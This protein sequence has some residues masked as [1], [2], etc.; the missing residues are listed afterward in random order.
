MVAGALK[1]YPFDYTQTLWVCELYRPEAT[2][3]WTAMTRPPRDLGAFPIDTRR[4]A[5]ALKWETAGEA[6][7]NDVGMVPIIPFENRVNVL[8]GGA[9]E[10]EDCVPILQRIDRLTLDQMLTSHYS[11]FRQK[12][13]TGLQVPT[14]PETGQ[15]VEPY[16]A[17]VNRLWVNENP[18]GSF[19]TFDASDL[20]QY[21]SAV[22][23]EIAKLAAISR[24][25]AH[26][27]MQRNLAN[28]PSAESLIASESGLAAKCE[29]RQ[30]S[31]GEAWEQAFWLR[32]ELAGQPIAIEE[33]EVDWVDAEK[34][35]P[36]QVADS[37][38]KW[39]AMGVP[40]PALWAY[41]GFTPQQVEE[42]QTEN[43]AQALLNAAT[44]PTPVPTAE[45]PPGEVPPPEA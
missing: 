18:Q 19:G 38:V 37:A 39:Q 11:S 2:Y 26:Y 35:N 17:A 41:G 36:A 8:S 6:A 21:L 4:R 33:I 25:P 1:L 15:R 30:A 20:G 22:D 34:R 14:D 27:L 7:A 23:A 29:D 3:R 32:A 45:L 43:A 24:V 10:I 5:N 16:K 12:W 13:A 9:S 28:P 42:W 31:Y 44:V 40:Q